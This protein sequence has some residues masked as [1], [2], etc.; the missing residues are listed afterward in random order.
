MTSRR[1][2]ADR[3]DA[4]WVEVDEHDVVFALREHFG[5]TAAATSCHSSNVLNARQRRLLARVFDPA[6]ELAGP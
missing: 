1:S 5:R 3:L 2:V 4:R 6:S